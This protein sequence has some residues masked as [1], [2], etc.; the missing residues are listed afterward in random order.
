MVRALEAEYAFSVA[1]AYARGERCLSVVYGPLETRD[2]KELVD[3]L[4]AQLQ[5]LASA[6]GGSPAQLIRSGGQS[7]RATWWWTSSAGLHADVVAGHAAD[8]ARQVARPWWRI[9]QDPA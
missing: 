5:Q 1:T 2:E 6:L 9:S 7:D 3:Q 8:L 4:N